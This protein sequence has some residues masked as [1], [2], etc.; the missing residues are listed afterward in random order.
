MIRSSNNGFEWKRKY[1][2]N[3]DHRVDIVRRIAQERKIRNTNSIFR[4]IWSLWTWKNVVIENNST[5]R[6]VVHSAPIAKVVHTPVVHAAPIV[7][8]PIVHAAPVVPVVKT[9]HGNYKTTNFKY[10]I[11]FSAVQLEWMRFIWNLI[12]STPSKIDWILSNRTYYISIWI[13]Q[14]P[15]LLPTQL[16][17]AFM[18]QLYIA[19]MQPLFLF[20]IKWKRRQNR[21]ILSEQHFTKMLWKEEQNKTHLNY[22]RNIPSDP[23]FVTIF[24]VFFLLKQ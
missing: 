1:I 17:T 18:H 23:F 5:F 13:F 9:V 14:P 19:F 10:I 2:K 7:H 3:I 4:K 6:H 22:F 12:Q 24:F 21:S 15:Q 16:C 11:H 8:S 20:I